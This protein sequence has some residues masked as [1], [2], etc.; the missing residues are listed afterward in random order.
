MRPEEK[1]LVEAIGNM[2]HDTS[3]RLGLL[4]DQPKEVTHTMEFQWNTIEAMFAVKVSDSP[5][6]ESLTAAFR[7]IHS[8]KYIDNETFH[9]SLRKRLSATGIPTEEIEKAVN[10]VNDIREELG[11]EDFQEKAAGW[12]PNL[13]EIADTTTNATTRTP[14]PSKPWHGGGPAPAKTEF[15]NAQ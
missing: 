11:G 9:L 13:D 14:Q 12:H 5:F 4:Q 2:F 8:Y 1:E 6:F 10:A 3:S 7:D 15:A